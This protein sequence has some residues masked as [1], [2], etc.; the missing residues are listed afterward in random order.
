MRK[1]K[2]VY[3]TGKDG[4]MWA[5]KNSEHVSMQTTYGIS[6]HSFAWR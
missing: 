4:V 6:F 3:S 5:K 1:L 2:D